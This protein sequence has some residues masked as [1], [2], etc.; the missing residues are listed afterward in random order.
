MATEKKENTVKMKYV[1][2]FKGAVKTVELPIP[3]ISNSMK[4]EQKLEFTRTT[5]KGPA[6]CEV[7]Y[8][9]AGALIQ[10]GGNFQLAE[11]LTPAQKAAVDAAH[12]E[13]QD[14]MKKL[15]LENELVEA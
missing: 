12:G 8:E 9:W 3:L 13:C 1:G 11:P 14:R 15:A 6:Y 4:L 7:P 2:V 5:T 10:L